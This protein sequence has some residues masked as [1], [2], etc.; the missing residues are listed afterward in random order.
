MCGTELSVCG[1]KLC[2]LL[3]LYVTPNCLCVC[4]CVC[5]VPDYV[6]LL[7]VTLSDLLCVVPSCVYVVPS[8]LLVVPSRMGV[9]VPSCS[10][11]CGTE[12]SE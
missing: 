9:V 12:L 6:C 4:V 1:T 2:V 8:C 11:G 5:V 3:Y 10:Y 7:Y